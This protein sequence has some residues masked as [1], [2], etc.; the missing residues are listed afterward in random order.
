MAWSLPA[1]PPL[2]RVHCVAVHGAESTGKSTLVHALQASLQAH[3]VTHAVVNETL[4]TWCE[5]QQRLPRA[6]EQAQIAHTHAQAI[7]DAAQS[8][9]A[10]LRQT[11]GTFTNLLQTTPP[12]LAVV[13]IDTTPLTTALYS[14]H[15]FADGQGIAASLAFER[16]I[17]QRLLLG[18]DLPWTP[19][20]GV[21]DG[22]AHQRA[23]DRLLRQ[24][25][26]DAALPH[27]VIYGHG[28]TRAQRAWQALQAGLAQRLL[29]APRPASTWRA[30]CE[31]CA[32]PACEW[33]LFT[34][35]RGD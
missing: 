26:Q 20:P 12:K 23:F 32:D 13:L 14:Q 25:L 9:Q 27:Q 5:A 22:P 6:D 3:G 19:E 10:S 4:R 29:N 8:L 30:A 31:C 28:Q 24:Q 21:R 17:K 11:S 35:A 16:G 18:L 15:H 33:A 7:V 1:W 34:Q 2:D